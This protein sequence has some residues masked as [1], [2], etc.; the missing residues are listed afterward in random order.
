[1]SY[2]T[3]SLG[4]TFLR[5]A[6][7]EC[8]RGEPWAGPWKT[9]REE[10]R[11]LELGERHTQISGGVEVHD[12]CRGSSEPSAAKEGDPD[13]QS[14][15]DSLVT[16]WRKLSATVCLFCF[17]CFVVYFIIFLWMNII[18]I[19]KYT[20]YIYKH[21]NLKIT[22]YVYTL[23]VTVMQCFISKKVIAIAITISNV[24]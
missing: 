3:L 19:N 1:M 23:N 10:E 18:I 7:W 20:L 17:V 9:S 6:S 13:R 2:K 12:L 4:S 15:A 11:E 21:Y 8:A 24:W 16:K 5:L 22:N 14:G